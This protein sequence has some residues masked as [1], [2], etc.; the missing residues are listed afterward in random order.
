MFSKDGFNSIKDKSAD[1]IITDFPYGTLNKRNE[2][3]K[4]IDYKLFWQEAK[5]IGNITMPVISTAQMP[6]SAVLI[7]TNYKD[8]K[9]TLVWEKSKATNEGI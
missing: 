8:F 6:F 3:D 5:R 9:Y 7:S 1:A 2:W 4:I